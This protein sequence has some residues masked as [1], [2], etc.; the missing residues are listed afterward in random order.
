MPGVS[1]RHWA[2]FDV[3][4]KAPPDDAALL[5]FMRRELKIIDKDT[6]RIIPFVL[7]PIQMAYW[8]NRT[9]A[10][11]ILKYRKGGF[12]TL[13]MAE[14]F[15]R[16]AMMDNQQVVFL[17]HREESTTLIFQTMHRFYD[18]LSPE[19]KDRLNGGKKA[20]VQSKRELKFARNGSQ[21][22][23]M[24]AASPD[25]LRGL[26][27]TM[28]HLSESAFWN[29]EWAEES[30]SSIMAALPPGGIIRLESTPSIA[31]SYAYDEWSHAMSGDSK[32]KP[33]FFAWWD[34]PTN[35]VDGIADSALGFL[36]PEEEALS[37]AHDLSAEQI[38]WRREKKKEQR[39]KF[40]REYPENP[41]SC[42][43]RSGGTVF[44]M[45]AVL[46]VFGRVEPRTLSE[47]GFHEFK[48][49]EQG[50]S[51]ILGVDTAS[52]V[53]DGDFSGIVAID[54]ETGEEVFEFFDR[55]PI[56][57]F[58]ERIYELGR[59][60]GDA[61]L[62]IE[63]NNHGHALIQYLTMVHPYPNML[64]DDDGGIGLTTT[65][66]SKALMISNLD[67]LFW[68]SELSLHGPALYRQLRSYVYDDHKKASAPKGQ[69]DDLVSSLLCAS[70][71]LVQ[72]HPRDKAQAEERPKDTVHRVQPQ[73]ERMDEDFAKQWST[74][75]FLGQMGIPDTQLPSLRCQ[76]C[77]HTGQILIN[78][79]WA[80]ENCRAQVA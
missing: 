3:E 9:P 47:P 38:A 25:A 50:H 12:S 41:E 70:W 33:H 18:H 55:L 10:D 60:Y 73:A 23:A 42:W 8:P 76:H 26:T 13:T 72:I 67:E 43:T 79:V 44:D 80:C 22:I 19:W 11:Y 66:K 58:G 31:G 29:P 21:I 17:A 40:T 14:F 78:G 71:A 35:R 74:R 64:E 20:Q 2:G 48:A 54:D 52:G 56:H 15:A 59:R 49:P 16:A 24:T 37:A 63:R 75:L 45:S 32:F 7:N 77:G 62:S 27:P 34:D 51:Y 1:E 30:A 61:T 6:N 53:Q 39:Q 57:E 65:Q 46:E 5:G 69:H 68:E 36:T 28:C 4:S